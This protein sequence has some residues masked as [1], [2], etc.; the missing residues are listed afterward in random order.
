MDQVASVRKLKIRSGSSFYKK[1]GE[2]HRTKEIFKHENFSHNEYKVP[3]NDIAVIEIDGTFTFN[4]NTTS[5]DFHNFNETI[6]P[7]TICN[8]SGWGRVYED[9]FFKPAQ[10]QTVEIPVVSKKNL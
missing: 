2:L 4:E 7:G 9:H 8:I 1:G 3:V 6:N 10:L 5:I